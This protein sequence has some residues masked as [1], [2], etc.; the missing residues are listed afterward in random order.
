MIETV[1][2]TGGAK[3]LGSVLCRHVAASGRHVCIHFNQSGDEAE[4]LK[5][6]LQSE[7]LLASTVQGDLANEDSV[8]KLVSDASVASGSRIT[9]LVNNAS[10]F[11]YDSPSLL[12][13]EVFDNSIAVNLKAP[14]VLSAAFI[15]QAGADANN[16]IVNILDQKLWNLNPDFFSYTCAKMALLGATKMMDMAY[17]PRARVCGIAPGLL[18]ES[19]D[20][21]KE[22]FERAS[23][24]NLL[25]EPIDPE[26]VGK[27]LV[28]ILEA[29]GMRGQIIHVDNGQRFVA[30]DRDVMFV[31]RG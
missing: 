11:D 25:Q 26:E 22:E 10:V 1:L 30:S 31:S 18:F 29:R 27:A 28:F 4:A 20:Q 3:R 23:A 5:R 13:P 2:V 12:R 8:A 9:A 14:L 6:Q 19:Y 7:G 16:V 17:A 15:A 24:V 21:T